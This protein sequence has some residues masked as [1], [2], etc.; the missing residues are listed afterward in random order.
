[1]LPPFGIEEVEVEGG[2]ALLSLVVLRKTDGWIGRR[3][4]EKEEAGQSFFRGAGLG[5]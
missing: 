3:K 4:E 2:G 5:N 1:M